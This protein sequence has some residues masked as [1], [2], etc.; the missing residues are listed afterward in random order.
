MIGRASQSSVRTRRFVVML[1]NYES[2]LVMYNSLSIISIGYERCNRLH[3]RFESAKQI[4]CTVDANLGRLSIATSNDKPSLNIIFIHVMVPI[5][6][7]RNTCLKKPLKS[8]DDKTGVNYNRG[9]V[10]EMCI[11]QL[12][13]ANRQSV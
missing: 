11:N 9:R 6:R 4:M 1:N 3:V 7:R 5:E 8:G 10:C 2:E 13:S 12:I